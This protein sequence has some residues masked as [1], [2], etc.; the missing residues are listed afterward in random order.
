VNR[1]KFL[2]NKR[3][4]SNIIGTI[5]FVV[6][7]ISVTTGV[8]FWTLMQNFVY[9]EAVLESNQID[10]YRFLEDVEAEN[11]VYT[12]LSGHQVQVSAKLTNLG[13]IATKIVN[14]WVYD[15]T[16]EKYGFND[17][18]NTVLN[19]NLKP[20]ESKNVSAIVTISGASNSD[21]FRS[22]F[23]TSRGNAISLQEKYELPTEL[24]PQIGSL[25]FNFVEFRYFTYQT[26]TRLQNYPSGTKS[27]NVP[28]N[29]YIAFGA[30]ITNVDPDRRTMTIDSHSLIWVP[31]NVRAASVQR[32]KLF[33]VVNVDSNGN[34]LSTFTDISIEYGQTKL[35]VFASSEDGSFSSA[36][37][38]KF[39]AIPWSGH[40][41][42][43]FILIHGT[44]D[45]TPYGQNIPFVALY[46][47]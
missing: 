4:A 8:F 38:V 2:R 11:G 6:I 3:G 37:R 9:Q 25:I 7:A 27:Y 41:I 47:E 26:S 34:I 1:I 46:V 18:I 45:S 20:G 15:V 24:A 12:V 19:L 13:S 32:G 33:Y 29:T 31:D 44:F 5:F 10:H 43:S 22:W 36:D 39:E 23:I 28:S 17:T 14:L 40:T 35:I 30:K 16:L 21:E 42:C